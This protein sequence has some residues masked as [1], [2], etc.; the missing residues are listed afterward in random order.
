MNILKKI[1]F[2]IFFF[3]SICFFSCSK[4]VHFSGISQSNINIINDSYL[5][6]EYSK[7]DIAKLIG[8]PIIQE[9]SGDLWIYHLKKKQGNATFQ[10]TLYNKTLKLKFKNNIL[11]SV[12]E[13]YID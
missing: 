12:E 3:L 2:L 6:K 7:D 11:R 5:N 1:S 4:D 9:D 8:S 13:I 10:K